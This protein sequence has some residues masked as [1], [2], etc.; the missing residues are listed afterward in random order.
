MTSL[1]LAQTCAAA[2]DDKKAGDILLLDMREIS[3]FTDYFLICSADSEPQMKAIANALRETVK[4]RHGLLPI[5]IDG[6]PASQWVVA[7]FGDVVVHLFHSEK[8][9]LYALEDLW[10]DAPRVAWQ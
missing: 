10:S 8:R 9:A 2:A 3:A 4:E 5:A 6:Y 1:A 7:D